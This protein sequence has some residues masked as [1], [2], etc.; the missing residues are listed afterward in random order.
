MKFI[1]KNIIEKLPEILISTVLCA[2]VGVV[3]YYFRGAKMAPYVC[4]VAG[5]ASAIIRP[6]YVP[7]K[8]RMES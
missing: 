8:K 5:A 2:L 3:I 4:A 1:Y 6:K 7:N